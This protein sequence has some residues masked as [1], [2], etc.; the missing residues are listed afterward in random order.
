[1]QNYTLSEWDIQVL[2]GLAGEAICE[3]EIFPSELDE[4]I[5]AISAHITMKL[6]DHLSCKNMFPK[7]NIE[8]IEKILRIAEGDQD[9]S[10]NNGICRIYELLRGCEKRTGIYGTGRCEADRVDRSSGSN[11]RVRDRIYRNA[12]SADL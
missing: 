9:G 7:E 12:A 5:M 10:K 4:M 11:W 6:L 1:M 8:A 2:V 3:D